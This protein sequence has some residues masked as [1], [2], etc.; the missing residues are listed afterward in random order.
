MQHYHPTTHSTEATK[1]Y[2]SPPP[3][4]SPPP[5][6]PPVL[7]PTSLNDDTDAL[8]W[9]DSLAEATTAAPKDN[10]KNDEDEDALV[11]E[12][13]LGATAPLSPEQKRKLIEQQR[14]LMASVEATRREAES[15]KAAYARN[16]EESDRQLAER[17]QREE[18]RR[19]AASTS[20]PTTSTG[21]AHRHRYGGVSAGG[22]HRSQRKSSLP[23]IV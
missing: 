18:N 15:N 2:L 10:D 4:I 1:E 11:L 14:E 3:G 23:E 13:A 21:R 17:L 8:A 20:V 16:L 5:F 6:A 12:A 7:P 19:A 9:M 22:G